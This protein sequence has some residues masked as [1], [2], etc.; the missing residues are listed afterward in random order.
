M[1]I[2]SKEFTSKFDSLLSE[3][4][5]DSDNLKISGAEA[6]LNSDFSEVTEIQKKCLKLQEL[7]S[8]LKEV[9]NQF[10]LE[11]EHPKLTTNIQT[12]AKRKTRT[13]GG[14]FIV[15]ISGL[16]LEKNTVADTFVEVLKIFGLERVSKLNKRVSSA[17]LLSKTQQNGYQTQRKID[18]WFITTHISKSSASKILNEISKELNIPIKI[19][20]AY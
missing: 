10:K 18:N 20:M 15:N 5:Q 16:T 19:N 17:P 3:I 13:V 4:H 2:L 9:L 11:Y 12:N 14:H 6:M 7:E 1:H 8:N